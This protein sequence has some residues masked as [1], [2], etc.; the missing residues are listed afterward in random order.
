MNNMN[1]GKK[2]KYMT[3]ESAE[4]VIYNMRR[5]KKKIGDTKTLNSYKCQHCTFWHIG[6]NK[7][8]RKIN[9]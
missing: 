5:N 8:L 3:E 7:L 9:G 6:H 4:L 2:K 1:K